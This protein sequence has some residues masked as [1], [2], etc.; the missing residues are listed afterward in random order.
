VKKSAKTSKVLLKGC[1]I[2][3]DEISDVCSSCF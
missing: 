3:L 1:L 2:V